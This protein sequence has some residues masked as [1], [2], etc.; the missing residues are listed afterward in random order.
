[1]LFTGADGTVSSN[2]GECNTKEDDASC[3]C[4]NTASV[5][6]GKDETKRLEPLPLLHHGC[7]VQKGVE[8]G[9]RGNFTPRIAVSRLS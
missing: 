3:H 5:G 7:G 9:V 8:H 1:M 4:D 6:K 2:A